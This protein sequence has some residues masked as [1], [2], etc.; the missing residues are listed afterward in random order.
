MCHRWAVE[1]RELG[2]WDT[3]KEH[4]RFKGIWNAFYSIKDGDNN[5]INNSLSLIKCKNRI[6]REYGLN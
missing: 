5:D 6:K 1:W 2:N 4:S 3:S